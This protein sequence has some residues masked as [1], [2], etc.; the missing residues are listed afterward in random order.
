MSTEPFEN[1]LRVLFVARRVE[2]TGGP[3]AQHLRGVDA[4]AAE[5]RKAR[6]FMPLVFA[7]ETSSVF[8]GAHV[9]DDVVHQVEAVG[10][11][12]VFV[13]EGGFIKLVGQNKTTVVVVE[14]HIGDVGL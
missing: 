5:T 14:A 1:L 12:G 2:L 13:N 9:D 4:R 8:G 10:V 11:N 7:L 3:A 6:P